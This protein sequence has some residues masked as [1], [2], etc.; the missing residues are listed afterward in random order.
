MV[1]GGINVGLGVK[2]QL[3]AVN[4][5]LALAWAGIV[6]LAAFGLLLTGVVLVIES[7]V[8]RWRGFR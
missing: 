4:G 7:R 6:T 8:L 3:S 2:I 1:A 5:Q